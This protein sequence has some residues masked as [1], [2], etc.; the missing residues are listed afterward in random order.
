MAPCLRCGMENSSN[1]L[2]VFCGVCLT[3]MAGPDYS[4]WLGMELRRN[5]PAPP[6]FEDW[7]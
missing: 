3:E 2:G 7:G 1:P 5:L 4:H 6:E